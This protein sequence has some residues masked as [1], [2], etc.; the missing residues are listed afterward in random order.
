[1]DKGVAGFRFNA[2]GK[3]YENKDFPDE[4]KS[5]GRES[6]PVYHSI[7]HKFTSDQPENIDAI[8]EW[9]KFMDDY[10]KRKNTFPR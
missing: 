5:V 6:W 4:P 3:L 7:T 10:S 1:M 8:V 2:V 9:R